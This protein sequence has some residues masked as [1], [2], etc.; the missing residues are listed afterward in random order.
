VPEIDILKKPLNTPCR[1]Q[2]EG[3]CGVHGTPEQPDL[4][5]GFYCDWALGFGTDSEDPRTVG[6]FVQARYEQDDVL[7][8][9]SAMYEC[10]PGALKTMRARLKIHELF[11]RGY[12]VGALSLSGAQ[13]IFVR[14]GIEL[15]SWYHEMNAQFG[16]VVVVDLPA[17]GGTEAAAL[18]V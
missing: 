7:G 10:V 11:G 5:K 15:S 4:C 8:V 9:V 1:F 18:Q 13:L 12:S 6:F 16:I 2:V 3:G 14:P 17:L